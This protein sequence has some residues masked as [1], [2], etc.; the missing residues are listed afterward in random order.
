MPASVRVERQQFDSA[1][2]RCAADLYLPAE[3]EERLPCV[4]LGH[5]FSATKDSFA[6]P[7]F[8]ERFAAAGLAALTFD[9]RHFGQSDGEPRQVVHVTRQR[10]DWRAAVRHARSLTRVDPQ[11]IALWGASFAGGHVLDLAAD[12]P[13]LAAAIVQVP[14]LDPIKG[15]GTETAPAGVQARLLIAALRDALHG[16]LGLPPVLV[17]VVAPY[18]RVATMTEPEANALL[19]SPLVAGTTWRNEFAPRVAFTM[20]RY[21]AG[22]AERLAMPVLFCIAERDIQ[23]SPRFALE[24]AAKAPRAETRIYPTGHFGLYHGTGFERAVADQLEFLRK[25]LRS[26]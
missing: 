10:A 8:A 16:R 2:L 11:R 5:G 15:A 22:T 18:G 3:A 26:G 1:G 4:V 19:S 9:Y 25:H 14:A 17:P 23:T 21:R 20:P 12:D 7:R 24:V 6:L 13:T